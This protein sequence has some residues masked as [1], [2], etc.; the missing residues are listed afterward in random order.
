MKFGSVDWEYARAER[1]PLTQMLNAE[2]K[3]CARRM[4]DSGFI[5][6]VRGEGDIAF[7]MTWRVDAFRVG[8]FM[9]GT[10]ELL[11]AINEQV[12][13][14]KR[15]LQELSNEVAAIHGVV[16]PALTRHV[17]QLRSARMSGR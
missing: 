10:V 15:V 3:T 4:A 9:E 13:E 6:G 16:A 5:T 1:H 17:T 8:R 11:A 12:E 14:S 7:Q 2:M